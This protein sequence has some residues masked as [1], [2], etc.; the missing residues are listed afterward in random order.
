MKQAIGI[1]LLVVM[2]L[3]GAVAAS[4]ATPAASST[5]DPA[6]TPAVT[7]NVAPATAPA[8]DHAG[9]MPG[10]QKITWEMRRQVPFVRDGGLLNRKETAVLM[11]V[12][13]DLFPPAV[14]VAIQRGLF[15]WMTVGLDVGGD[16]GIFQAFLRIKQEMGRARRTN[17][18]F[19]GWHI[20]TGYKYV[21]VD[22]RDTFGQ[23]TDIR[24]DDNSWV[25]AFQNTFSLRFGKHRR[26]SMYLTTQVYGDF[27][28]RGKGIQPDLYIY[29][30][31]LGFETILGRNWNFFFEVGVILSINGWQLSDKTMMPIH[32]TIGGKGDFFPTGSMGFA[33]RF[34]GVSTAL[35]SNW[36][37]PLAPPMK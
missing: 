23:D 21:N 27:D 18:F 1:G 29:P 15:Y 16:M 19:W 9:E 20:R 2:I 28:L 3:N 14:M 37:D 35:P 10:N 7:P 25:L 11:Y 33:Y 17:F 30:A 26:R 13:A 31:T 4:D 32:P 6:A 22:M 8:E 34:G 36:R 24:F 5:V 12:D